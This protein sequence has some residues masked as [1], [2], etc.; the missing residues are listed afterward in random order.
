MKESLNN[1]RIKPDFDW[2]DLDTVLLDMDGT[3][4][5]KYFDAIKRNVKTVKEGGFYGLEKQPEPEDTPDEG[6]DEATSGHRPA[7]TGQT[8]SFGG[9]HP[10]V[11]RP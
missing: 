5:D 1:T 7:R 8:L 11:D 3:L 4:L 6:G 2:D 10:S 9:K